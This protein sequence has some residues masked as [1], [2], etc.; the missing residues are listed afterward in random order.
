[1]R[2][3]A[4]GLSG[5]TQKPDAMFGKNMNST[6]PARPSITV[7][8]ISSV[9]M[10]FARLSTFSPRYL[11]HIICAPPNIRAF[12]VSRNLARG[13]YRPAAA[14]AS[15]PI[16]LLAKALS[17]M[18]LTPPHMTSSICRGT[19]LKNNCLVIFSSY[20]PIISYVLSLSISLNLYRSLS[21]I[22][23]RLTFSL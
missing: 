19:M 9:K 3:P 2:S 11:P 8:T 7:V 5:F 4:S 17:M 13:P 14:I 21:H 16:R 20:L 12:T 10:L 6:V 23:M 1:M 15:G 22:S 18:T